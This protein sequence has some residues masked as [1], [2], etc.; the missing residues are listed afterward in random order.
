MSEPERGD[1]PL[2]MT[3][4]VLEADL[5]RDHFRQNHP[6]EPLL[7]NEDFENSIR[8]LLDHRPAGSERIDGVYLFAYGS[9]VWNPCIEVAERRRVVLEGYHRDFCLDL[10]Q[11]RGT[12]ECPGLM[13]ALVPGGDSEGV[14]LR[15]AEDDLASELLLVWRREM[16]TGAYV[17]HWVTLDTDEGALPG[18]AF[19]ANPAHPRYQPGLDD[20]TIVARLAVASGVLGSCLEYL[21][22]TVEG[23]R[24]LGIGDHYLARI[25][26]AVHARHRAQQRSR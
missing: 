19:I 6:E 24:D 7:S 23:L 21:D 11:G 3:R 17:P 8:S 18:I 2:A 22:N 1:K 12:P 14:A 9:L 15:V 26:R 25:Q 5:I 10:E 13:L 16:I 20:A 4:E